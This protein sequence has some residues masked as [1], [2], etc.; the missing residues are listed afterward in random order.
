MNIKV[1]EIKDSG[2]FMNER[3]LFS[4]EEKCNLGRFLVAH[5]RLLS[6]K[7]FSSKLQEIYWFPD[8]EISKGDLVVL[9][10]KRGESNS[11]LNADG[12]NTHFYYWGLDKPL[13]N[14]ERDC[15]VLLDASWHVT[16]L[17]QQVSQIDAE[18]EAGS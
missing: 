16:P 9:Y 8:K 6:E 13:A 12:T 4:V 7:V 1:L 14:P 15:L 11:V 5:S 2:D 3:I 18:P 10:S 17:P